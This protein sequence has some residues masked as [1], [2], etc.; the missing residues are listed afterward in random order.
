MVRPVARLSCRVG[1]GSHCPGVGVVLSS[2]WEVCWSARVG[3][4]LKSFKGVCD[5]A[6]PGSVPGET[7]DPAPAGGNELGGRGE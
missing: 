2:G 5:L 6:C 7:E 3:Q 1:A 4:E